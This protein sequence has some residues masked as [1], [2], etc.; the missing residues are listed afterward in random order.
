[1]SI[2]KLPYLIVF[3]SLFQ[4]VAAQQENTVNWIGFEQLEDSL[5]IKP[6]KVF[7]NFYADWCAYCKKMD[8]AAFKDPKVVSKLNDEY[9]AVKMNVES[10]D[11][12]QFSGDIFIN[13][14]LG[15][16]RNPT[17]QIPLFLASRENR[18][19][20]LPALV[21]L[22]EKFEVSNRYF[23]YLSPNQLLSALEE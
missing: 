14:Q 11:S 3:W 16:F 4:S 12:I 10:T 13:E 9:Y 21:F 5:N 19:F 20:S 6:K 23:E 8:K 18:P 7:I 2:K 1:M 15:K 17:H 22:N